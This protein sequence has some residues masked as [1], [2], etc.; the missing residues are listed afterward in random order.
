[1]A[2]YKPYDYDQLMMV[3]ISLEDLALTSQQIA[4]EKRGKK[5]TADLNR[6][7]LFLT[8]IIGLWS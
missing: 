4:E 8:E 3:P 7:T 5:A 6:Y 1:M 2:Q